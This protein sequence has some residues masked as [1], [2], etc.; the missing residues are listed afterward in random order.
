[1][2]SSLTI[3]LSEHSS[4]KLFLFRA[5]GPE[6]EEPKAIC[7]PFHP[8]PCE[9]WPLARGCAGQCRLASPPL[10]VS[11]VFLVG[12]FVEVGDP[13]PSGRHR[14]HSDCWSNWTGGGGDRRGGLCQGHSSCP[15][16]PLLWRCC[17]PVL[18]HCCPEGCMFPSGARC[19]YSTL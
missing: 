15:V 7:S 18:S 1:M 2:S 4:L 10:P 11:P 9:Q 13:A 12:D 5:T 16:C 17:L 3:S 14:A 8:T 19:F 6:F